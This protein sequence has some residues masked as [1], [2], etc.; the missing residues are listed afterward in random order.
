MAHSSA[1]PVIALLRTSVVMV[2]AIVATCPMRLIAPLVSRAA[3]IALSHVS[4]AETTY[5][6]PPRIFVT[7][8]MTA[9][10]APM[11]IQRYATISIVTPC[12]DSSAPTTDA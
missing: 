10:T 11:R 7:A 4:S 1:N 8:P 3:D 5:A 6:F 12:E 2:T 9:V